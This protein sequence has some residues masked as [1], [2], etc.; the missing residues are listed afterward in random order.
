MSDSEGFEVG[1]LRSA[2][3]VPAPGEPAR[4]RRRLN[5]LTL[6]GASLMCVFLLAD[7]SVP[8]SRALMTK[9]ARIDGNG[10][11]Y[12]GGFRCSYCAWFYLIPTATP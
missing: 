12:E 10:P 3:A 9:W 2:P 1:G 7:F 8:N 6:V 11:K 4:R 5:E